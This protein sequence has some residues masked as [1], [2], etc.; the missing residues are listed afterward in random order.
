MKLLNPNQGWI[1]P[2]KL[3]GEQQEYDE[4]KTCPAESQAAEN[5]FA[6]VYE[7]N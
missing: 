7:G 4:S 5:D 6:C 1:V 2:T 3:D